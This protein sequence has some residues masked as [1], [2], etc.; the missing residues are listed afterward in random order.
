MEILTLYSIEGFMKALL[1]ILVFMSSVVFAQSRDFGQSD[2][3]GKLIPAEKLRYQFEIRGRILVFDSTG[4]RLQFLGNEERVWRFNNDKPITSVWSFK[5]KGLP[6]VALEHEWQVSPEGVLQ[7]KIKQFDSVEYLKNA[8]DQNVKF[9]KLLKEK[10]IDVENFGSVSWIVSQTDKQRVVAL[11]DLN[12][13]KNK[14]DGL[15][16]GALPISSSRLTIYDNKGNLWATGLDNASENNIFYSVSTHQGTVYLSYKPFKGGKMIG[17][18]EKNRIKIDDGKTKLT[19]E[20]AN[21]LV[22]QYVLGK[23]YAYI[24]LNDKTESLNQVRS[25]SSSDEHHFMKK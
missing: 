20:S 5:Q 10:T 15:D 19:I 21:P 11:F 4:K 17:N 22:P 1:L 13:W 14:G 9:G 3:E 16:L 23:V 18:V 6:D 8:K 24:D 2:T 25:N 12:L 7:T